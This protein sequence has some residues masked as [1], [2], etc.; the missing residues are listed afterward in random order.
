MVDDIC[1]LTVDRGDRKPFFDFCILQLKEMGLNGSDSIF[2]DFPPTSHEFDLVKRFRLGVERAKEKG[3]DYVCVVESDDMYPDSYVEI[4]F[5]NLLGNDFVGFT[6]TIYYN[7]RNRTWM[8][9]SHPG[10]S[11]LFCTGFRVSAL[12]DFRWPADHY[13]FLDIRLWEHA[14]DTRKKV[15]LMSGNPCIGIKHNVGL[16][17]GK[18]HKWEMGNRDPDLS[19]LRSRTSDFHFEFYSKLKL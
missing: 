8:T 4:M 19:F 1:T 11:S 15:K 3:F 13:L 9:Q 10:R 17:G 16:C 12:D 5:H 2:V 6:D 14:R 7:I 18:A